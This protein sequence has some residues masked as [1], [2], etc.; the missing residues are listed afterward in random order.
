MKKIR[1]I[2]ENNLSEWK[3]IHLGG[4][5]MRIIRWSYHSDDFDKLIEEI[6]DNLELLVEEKEKQAIK[7]LIGD[8][9]AD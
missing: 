6:E 4:G 9:N 3:E 2:L 8:K 1:E 5:K 7:N